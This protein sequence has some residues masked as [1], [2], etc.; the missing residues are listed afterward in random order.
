MPHVPG[1]LNMWNSLIFVTWEHIA[2]Y[3][4][5]RMIFLKIVTTLATIFSFSLHHKICKWEMT[6]S[7]VGVISTLFHFSI[8]Y[9]SIHR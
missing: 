1:P 9:S 7:M 6:C 8:V 2:V 5:S 3:E 4:N